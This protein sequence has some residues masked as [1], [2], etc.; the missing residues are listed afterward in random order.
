MRNYI[1]LGSFTSK[2]KKVLTIG[3]I[4]SALLDISWVDVIRKYLLHRKEFIRRTIY[5]AGFHREEQ[6]DDKLFISK[7]TTHQLELRK[8]RNSKK[9][10]ESVQ[11]HTR[12]LITNR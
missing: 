7:F 1:V 6:G 10:P 4:P 11:K 5:K 12:F 8:K 2:K 9:A 3:I